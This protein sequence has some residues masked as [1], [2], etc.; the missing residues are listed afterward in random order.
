MMFFY[1][2]KLFLK[3][4]FLNVLKYRWYFMCIWIFIVELKNWIIFSK[5]NSIM[6]G[7]FDWY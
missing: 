3:D 4:F 2:I 1:L 6:K 7:K 5:I